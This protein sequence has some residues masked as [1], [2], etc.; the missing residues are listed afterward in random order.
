MNIN[1][2]T[3]AYMAIRTEREAMSRSFKR[4]DEELKFPTDSY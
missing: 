2:L 3:E 4:S 1:E